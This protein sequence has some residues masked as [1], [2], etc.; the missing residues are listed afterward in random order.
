MRFRLSTLKRSKTIELHVV[1]WVELCAY[2]KHRH[3]RPFS[4]VHTNTICM[5]FCFCPI[6][7]AFSNRWVVDEN[8][9]GISMDGRPTRSEMYPFSDQV[10]F[11]TSNCVQFQNC[12]KNTQGITFTRLTNYKPATSSFCSRRGGHHISANCISG[13]YLCWNEFSPKIDDHW[14]WLSPWSPFCFREA[15][16]WNSTEEFFPASKNRLQSQWQNYHVQ[17]NSQYPPKTC[18]VCKA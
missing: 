9:Q 16:L 17:R 6:S 10:S 14:Y 5:S 18:Q 15:T 3:L 2:Y 4:T 8:P 12:L 1:T 7:R 11:I 13:P